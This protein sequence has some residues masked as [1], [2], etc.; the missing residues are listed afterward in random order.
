[1]CGILTII[2]RDFSKV[3]TIWV[4]FGG[5]S[6]PPPSRSLPGV[7]DGARLNGEVGRPFY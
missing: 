4:A 6:E 7:W 1:M 2:V 5:F 3:N